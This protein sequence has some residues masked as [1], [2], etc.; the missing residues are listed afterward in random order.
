MGEENNTT[1]M[2]QLEMTR[3]LIALI[4]KY[5][6]RYGC[7]ISCEK[8]NDDSPYCEILRIDYRIDTLCQYPKNDIKQVEPLCIYLA[9]DDLPLVAPIR[10]DFKRVPH[11]NI[12]ANGQISLCLFDLPYEEIKIQLNA[13]LLL[14]R[15]EYWFTKTARDELHQPDQPLDPF[16]TYVTDSIIICLETIDA[17][18]VLSFS[19][20]TNAY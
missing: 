17:L 1:W 20:I 19:S 15:I 13:M 14:Q 11:T 12:D 9:Q 16:F 7:V 5:D 3:E 18:P 2:P 6:G 10:K 8:V 4:K